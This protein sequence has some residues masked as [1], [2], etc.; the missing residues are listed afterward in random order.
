MSSELKSPVELE[1]RCS[2]CMGE[3]GEDTEAGWEPC[4]ICGGSG[5]APT[6]LGRK[7]LALVEHHFRSIC[8]R[9]RANE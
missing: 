3:G 1:Q 2:A 6:P 7:I 4:W 8:E 5:F 9:T